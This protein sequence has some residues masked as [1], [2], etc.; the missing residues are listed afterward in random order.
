MP[1]TGEIGIQGQLLDSAWAQ[2]LEGFTLYKYV[3][4][5]TREPPSCSA[6]GETRLRPLVLSMFVKVLCVCLIC[7]L[8]GWL[9]I[10]IYMVHICACWEHI[11]Y[12][13]TS[14]TWGHEGMSTSPLLGCW[15]YFPLTETTLHNMKCLPLLIIHITV[16]AGLYGFFKRESKFTH[17]ENSE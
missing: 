1:A 16:S 5:L 8:Y 14:Q 4:I 2:L 12:L 11:Y 15:V 9:C 17:K 7:D 10:W 6:R 13:T 3:Y